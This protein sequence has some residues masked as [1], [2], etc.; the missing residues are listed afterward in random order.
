MK[1]LSLFSLLGLTGL[2]AFAATPIYAQELD[3]EPDDEIVADTEDMEAE[4]EFNY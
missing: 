1:K 3:V 4:Y 2:L